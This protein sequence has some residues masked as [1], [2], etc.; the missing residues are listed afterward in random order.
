MKIKTNIVILYHSESG[1]TKKL[2]LAIAQG[3]KQNNTTVNVFDVANLLDLDWTTIDAADGIIFGSPTFMGC[4]S[5]PFKKFMDETGNFWTDQK[6]SDKLAAGFTIGSA[7]S[8]DK[9]NTLIQ[10]NIFA[11]Q[12]GMIW[13]GQNQLGSLYTN[14]NQRIN[15]SGSWLGLMGTSSRDKSELVHDGDIKTAVFFGERMAKITSIFKKGKIFQE[16]KL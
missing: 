9:L 16:N 8:G 14:D 10:L 4:V 3:A 5:A 7:L 15:E 13:V 11:C 6:W 12:H 1:H 2:A